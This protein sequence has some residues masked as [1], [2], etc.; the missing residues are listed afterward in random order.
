MNWITELCDLYDKNQERVGKV[1]YLIRKG[2]KGN[3]QV[4][5]VL[6]P[7]FH[8]TVEAQITVYINSKGEFQGATEVED[9][10]GLTIIPATESSAG[11]TSGDSAHPLCDNL[12][13]L[14]GDYDEYSSKS[15]M[16]KHEMYM[17]GLEAW[18][19]SKYTHKK[20]N[21]IYQYLQ[22]RTLIKDL[23]NSGILSLDDDG[24]LSEKVKFRTKIEQSKAFVRFCI[25]EKM[26]VSH[27]ILGGEVEYTPQECW[28][29]TSLHSSYIEYYRSI[30]ETEN[31]KD[32]SY[33]TGEYATISYFHS[34]KIR[35]E[36]DGSKLI[37]SN[38]DANFTFR[39][40]FADKQEAFAVGYEESQKFHNALKW[41]IRKQGYSQKEL[42]V[43]VWESSLQKI[44]SWN[45]DTDSICDESEID[46]YESLWEDDE[47]NEEKISIMETGEN[48]AA[49]F[50]NAMRGY[51]KEVKSDSR[52]ILLA[53][54]S[55]TT[56]R[57]AMLENKILEHSRYLDNIQYW[58]S[59]CTWR[60]VKYKNEK[61]YPY[62][63]MAGVQDIIE[64]LYG[65]E[66]DGQL[67]VHINCAQIY[68]KLLS[69][70][71][72]R[73]KIAYDFVQVA[74]QK[75]SSP[76]SYEK[77]YNW[78]KVLGIACSLV[79][80]YRFETKQEEWNMELDTK[81]QN[82]DYLYGRLFAVAD[83]VEYLTY[84]FEEDAKRVTNA[85]RYMKVFSQRPYQT[86]KLLEENI[87][88]YLNKL[89]VKTR[90]YY[91]K[92][93]DDIY[94]LFKEEDFTDNKKLDGLYL[95]GY[96][97]QSFEFRNSNK[98]KEEN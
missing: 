18:C 20:V 23:V 55:A 60:Q 78:E 81:N 51:R 41:I 72:N 54:D 43:V 33:L 14:A 46:K 77:Y 29:D 95:L 11:R 12:E 19:F 76:V 1:E 66:Q 40:R 37:S 67:S 73:K 63:G 22:K 65:V 3:E 93:L 45:L 84:N 7:I 85:K 16:K 74:V 5:V 71:S 6:L 75:A 92:L 96:H 50:K 91:E 87:R 97:C 28:L 83:R 24:K 32:I 90:V 70:I 94:H 13:Y 31:K 36:G 15:N 10:A 88:P 48:I 61:Y 64:A 49:R 80:K 27:N 59:H 69:C 89:E 42:C 30:L 2:K 25:I 47:D 35:N 53:F 98:V 57:L 68:R 17:Q 82:R 44:P 62:E 56:G 26:E 58:H 34:K 21:A 86:W 38:D 39:G 79:K 8:T 9:G 4:P 52:V